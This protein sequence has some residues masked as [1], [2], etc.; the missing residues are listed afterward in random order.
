MKYMME[1]STE[2]LS[3]TEK[4]PGE[5][6]ERIKEQEYPI[7]KFT[8]VEGASLSVLTCNLETQKTETKPSVVEFIIHNKDFD[9]KEKKEETLRVTITIITIKLGKDDDP[10]LRFFNGYVGEG[11]RKREV[12]GQF[13]I[14][15]EGEKKKIG[16][17][18]F[19]SDKKNC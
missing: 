16:H 13:L 11:I 3:I 10:R 9:I 4:P 7:T 6:R 8:V 18:R 14:V 19:K 2:K 12:H 15:G 5:T 1:G 17:I